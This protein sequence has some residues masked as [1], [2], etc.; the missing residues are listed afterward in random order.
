LQVPAFDITRQNKSL[1]ASLT[2]AFRRAL[3]HGHFILGDEVKELEA[4]MAAYLG[5]RYVITVANGSDALVLSLMAL[6]IK[7]GDEVIVPGFTFFATAGSVSRI[8]AIPVFVDVTASDYNIDLEQI[9]KKITTKTKV[10]IPVH[11]FGMPANMDLLKKLAQEY[12]LA[13]IE[14]AAQALGTTFQGKQ[15]GTI[16]EVGCFSFFPTKNLGC[17]GDG[18][19]VATNRADLAEQLQ[20]LRVHGTRKK[21]YHEFLGFNSRLDTI[22]AAFLNIKLPLLNQSLESRRRIAAIYR[23]EFADIAEIELPAES[24]GHSYNQFTIKINNRDCLRGFLTENGIGTTVYYPLALHLQPVFHPL[25]YQE[26]DLP[27]SEALTTRVVSLPLFPEMTIEEQMYVVTKIK[28]F[29]RKV[30]R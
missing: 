23:K 17:F 4:K 21:Y 16:G 30:A 6:G 8:G 1:E 7:P 9:R 25:G 27:V 13:L 12:N 28:E 20:M 26:G 18:G 3:Q 14:D 2:Q 29:F 11:L 10:I 24:A 5:V 22:Q 15:V 19:M